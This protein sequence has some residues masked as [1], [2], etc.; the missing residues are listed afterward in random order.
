MNLEKVMTISSK[1]RDDL[2]KA[3]LLLE[4]PGIA[5]KMINLLGTPIEKGFTLLPKDWSV[6][7]GDATQAALSAAMRSAL[8]TM[9]GKKTEES[10]DIWH[11]IAAATTGGVG[12]LFG[13]PALA[14]ELPVSTAIMLRSIADIA[15]SEGEPIHSSESKMACIEVF[16]FGGPSRSDDAAESGYFAVRAALARSVSKAAEYV[17]THEITE[18]GAPALAR[19]IIRIAKRF[20]IPVTEKAAAQALPAVGAVGG[21]LINTLFIDHFQ[22]M[23]RGHFIVRRLEKKYGPEEVRNAYDNLMGRF[24]QDR[25]K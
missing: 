4:N 21:A 10:S 22:D 5:A 23:A 15:R 25:R 7:V 24:G 11:K 9:D 13:L 3:K 2:K 20:S 19:L 17:A 1:D 8:F 12:G 18:E 16:A 14:V 6:L